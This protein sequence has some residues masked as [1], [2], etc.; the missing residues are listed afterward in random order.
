MK[1]SLI[2][3][4][5]IAVP[6][7]AQAQGAPPSPPP[8]TS[9][10][11]PAVAAGGVASTSAPGTVWLGGGL[12]ITAAG[13]VSGDNGMGGTASLD[14][15][16]AFA[17]MANLDYQL[18]DLITLRAMPRYIVS[19]KPQGASQSESAF[20]LRVGATVGKEVAPQI[21][22]YGLG[23]LGYASVSFPSQ[24]GTNLPNAT[25]LTLTFGGGGAY[26]INPTTRLYAELAYELGFE[27]LSV[28]GVNQDFKVNW[29]ELGFGVQIALGGH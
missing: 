4:S 12:E 29:L 22:L 16:S 13:S 20:D 28:M 9:G 5:L 19:I 7:L 18:N 27:S 21:R 2:L 10:G 25:G 24:M 26:T 3:L 23:A 6:A 8:P 11:T 14:L 15:D 1:K 17:F